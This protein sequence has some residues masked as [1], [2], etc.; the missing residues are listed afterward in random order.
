[1]PPRKKQ[2]SDSN[3]STTEKEAAVVAP[4][5]ALVKPAAK[6]KAKAK[7]RVKK[8][9]KV[10][11]K[12]TPAPEKD[13]AMVKVALHKTS[14][15]KA[16][17]KKA[18][19]GIPQRAKRVRQKAF[20]YAFAKPEIRFNISVACQQADVSRRTYQAWKESD[21]KFAA[22]VDEVMESQID[23][24]EESLHKNILAGD[25]TSVIFALKT[26]G[27]KRG[28]IEK[29]HSTDAKENIILDEFIAGTISAL[30]AGIRIH[31]MGRA[32]PKV[33]ELQLAKNE[34]PAPPDDRPPLS[35]E[36]LEAKYQ[37]SLAIAE[38]QQAGFLPERREEVR[39]LK[40]EMKA[41]EQFGPDGEPVGGE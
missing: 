24:W 8:P 22:E 17:K 36:D 39:V 13:E 4:P 28:W 26:K 2:Q 27:R 16:K 12:V 35:S 3:D 41:L 37:E 5:S 32:L 34:P 14:Q 30:D 6:K 20:L 33:L 23:K 7:K 1:M 21:P 29:D 31:K 40:D 11:E 19:K 9:V 25:A 10:A 18:P 38:G 15:G